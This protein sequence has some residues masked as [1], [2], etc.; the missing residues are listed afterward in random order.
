FTIGIGI[1]SSFGGM[2]YANR[3]NELEDWIGQFGYETVMGIITGNIASK[4][5]TNPRNSE[6]SK[7]IKK[8]FL[9]RGTGLVDMGLFS[10]L[11]GAAQEEA[12][13][14]LDEILSDPQRAER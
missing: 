4:I 13:V 9:S 1:V 3:D 14:R 12:A 6:L 8:Y 10:L 2:A 11:F 7:A 5:I